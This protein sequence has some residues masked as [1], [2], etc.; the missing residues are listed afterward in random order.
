MARH[1]RSDLH[2]GQASLV[3]P[4][5]IATS[6]G[7]ET[8][9]ADPTSSSL[10]WTNRWLRVKNLIFFSS[11]V[12][13]PIMRISIHPKKFNRLNR[14][15]KSLRDACALSAPSWGRDVGSGKGV[16]LRENIERSKTTISKPDI[17]KTM[18][19]QMDIIGLYIV[20][21][22]GSYRQ[23]IVNILFNQTLSDTYH[24]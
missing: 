11:R 17:R 23:C 5:A 9:R 13:T 7:W 21:I 16:G 10:K 24:I 4:S 15:L 8:H 6:E 3:A 22:C 19:N 18:W 12:R 2:R 1:H 14:Q 20:S